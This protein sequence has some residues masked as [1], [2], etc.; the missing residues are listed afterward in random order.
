VNIWTLYDSPTDA[1]GLFVLRRFELR[2]GDAHPTDEA[3]ASRSIETLRAHMR[4][5][6]RYCIP[7]HPNDE[8]A[9]VECWL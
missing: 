9:I 8:P 4:W 3:Y 1:P 7:R 6:G 2:D 5:E